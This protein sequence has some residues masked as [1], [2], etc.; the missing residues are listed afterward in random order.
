MFFFY[1]DNLKVAAIPET[2]ST[3]NDIQASWT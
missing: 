1:I 2:V 3:L